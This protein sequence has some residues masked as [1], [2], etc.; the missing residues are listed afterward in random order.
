MNMLIVVAF[1][2]LLSVAPVLALAQTPK[3]VTKESTVTGTARITAIDQKTRSMTL[4]Y[5]DGAEETFTVEPAVTRFYQFKVGDSIRATY[6]ESILLEVRKPGAPAPAVDA[7][8]VA[9]RLKQ[10]P[11]A[12]AAV[13]QTT[14]VTV[15]AIDMA[16]ATI[17]VTT[18]DGMTITRKAA[19]PKNLEGVKVG[20]TID[21]YYSQG[22]I[23]NL[24]PAK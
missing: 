14:S 12:A 20:D 13:M 5:A 6:T 10:T 3:P 9:G 4:R 2:G 16:K 7:A 11:G 22:L 18:K 24:E 17:S 15:K 23:L 1:A 19:N 8:A 21:I